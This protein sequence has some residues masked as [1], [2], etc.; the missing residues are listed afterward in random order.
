MPTELRVHQLQES[1]PGLKQLVLGAFGSIYSLISTEVLI[2]TVTYIGSQ[3]TY[4]YSFRLTSRVTGI[5][6]FGD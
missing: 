1:Q 5:S 4:T 3:S 2:F 6:C